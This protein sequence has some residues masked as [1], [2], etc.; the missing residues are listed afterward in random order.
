[1]KKIFTLLFLAALSILVYAD[2]QVS[3]VVVD[4]TGEPVVGA[5][6]QAAGTTQGTISDYD[7]KFEM[8][9]PESV[10]TL[11]VSFV[12]MATQEV[13]A[14]RN[15][16]I[17]L[18]ENSEVLQ[19]VV[20][21]GYGVVAKGAY[22]GSAQAVKAEDIEKK[23]PS[24]ITKALAGEVSGVQVVTSSGQP[25]TVASIRIRGIGSISASSAP[26]YVVDGIPLDAGSI[27]SIDPSDIASTTILKDAT[28]TSLYGSR[29]A[30]G[31]ILITT[32]KGSSNGD[33]G[34][35]E[36]DVKGGA[37]MRLLPMY[38]VI[39]SPE[40][41]I[42]LGWQ[43]LYNYYKKNHKEAQSID[44]AN[45]NLFGKQ[46]IPTVYNLWDQPGNLLINA[47]DAAGNV[48]PTFDPSV[49]RK[50][51][52][53]NMENWYNTL[54]HNGLK[55]EATAKISG[56]NEKLNYYTS[57]GYLKDEGYYTASDFQ[58]FNTR[59]NV[60]Y[61]AKK[62]LKGGLNIQYSYAAISN[63]VQDDN[64]ANNGF[65][66][67]NQI[68]PIYPVY[69]HDPVT[70]A[71]MTD[72]KTGG[73]MYD[74]GD[75]GNPKIGEEGGRPY[76]FGI[77]PAGALQWDKQLTT[78]HQTV[79][80]AFLE[81][82]LYEGLKFTINLGA[83]YMNNNARSLT[84][85]YYGDAAGVGRVAQ[86]QTNYLA[87]TSNQLLEYSKTFNEHSIRVMAG[88]ETTYFT[89]NLQY[90]YKKNIV[91]DNVVQL[92][93]G[94]VMDGVE[95]YARTST[96]ESALATAT[97]EYDNRYL[98]TGNYRAD[99]S[100]K[101]A[102][103]H[104]WGHFGS[105][106]A[107]WNFTNEHFMEGTEAADWLKN[108]KLRLSWG[109]LGNQDIGDMMFTDQYNVENV[110]GDKG[111]VWSYK[112][113]PD[114]TWERTSTIDLGL[115]LSIGKYLDVE[116]DYFYK[117]TDNM[118]FPRYVAPSLGYG[119]YYV[120]D[121]A[122]ENQGFEFDLKAHVLDLRNVRLDIKLN[123]GFYRNKMLQMPID[124]YD[125]V[126]GDPVR[127]VMSGG[128]S[129]GHSTY[130]WYMT[131]YEGVDENGEALY[132]AYYDANKGGF[133]HTSADLV[134]DDETED[135]YISSVYEYRLKHPNANIQ[136]TTVT[137]SDY[138]YAG[139]DYIGKSAM[140]D[141]DGG[142][143]LSF[144]AYGVTLDISCAYRIGGYGYDNMYA[145]LMHSEKVGKQNWHTDIRN[146]WTE[147][148]KNDASHYDGAGNWV[149]RTSDIPRLSNGHDQYANA[150]SD[151]FLTSNS[152]LQ[153]GNINL[154]Y[155]FPKKLIEK[156][157]LNTLHLWVAADNLAIA[158]ARRGY[159]PMMSMSG[160]NGYNDYSPLSTIMGGVKIQF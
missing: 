15:L 80:N 121:A 23:N 46:G 96:L 49:S 54:F 44:Y 13:A 26:L 90:G 124:G 112:G 119:G 75:N 6:I 83:Q 154:G 48:N 126:T 158:T 17:V 32:K 29:G 63:P 12:G 109:V 151:R 152:Y 37:N 95:G 61:Q 78:R 41:Y 143:G 134:G 64:A 120:N 94:V 131:H 52:Y 85:K 127:M 125:P 36:I 34:K 7:G 43:G 71:I 22:A 74:Y 132:T 45:K 3:G 107:A 87:V 70:G 128:M 57:F 153:L 98:I 159:N 33:E 25:G 8:S 11:V 50:P 9:V 150:A 53:A 81:F 5:S 40:E 117:M 140:P 144:E 27:S 149:P 146:A 160:T 79:A 92:S 114:L 105:V 51:A 58:R 18:Q 91:E 72:P 35:I 156:I 84:N 82:K 66:F 99:G 97:Y 2:Q 60:Q 68:P 137:G 4:A 19:D 31:V 108:G 14:G 65:L 106:G 28:A 101:F 123:G 136:K 141:L 111:Y 1:M 115:E 55:L 10:K 116:L 110:D 93:N 56:G 130:D 89:Y 42:T 100:S 88:H 138:T 113:N 59:A 16:K 47:Y 39:T 103:G 67:V 139:S 73:K 129:A 30:N 133:G 147:N 155:K 38:D 142:F 122:M 21:T 145:Y 20:V 62:W 69:V 102:K 86:T 104:R 148:M 24:D 76:S 157:K 135:N 118:L 77:N